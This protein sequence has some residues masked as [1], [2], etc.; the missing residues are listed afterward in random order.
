VTSCFPDLNVWLALSVPG[1]VHGENAWKWLRSLPDEITLIFSRQ[2]QLGLLR[3]L[4]NRP[5]MGE[6][7]LTLGKAWA[8][9]RPRV[10]LY[11][12]PRDLEAGFR[13]VTARL[14][15]WR[16]RKWSGDCYLLAFASTIT[17]RF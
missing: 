6:Y 8:V 10:E 14:P 12:E 1:H 15:L 7:T 17:P 11:A 9:L 16:L 5:A 3:L 4:T 13:E 2:T